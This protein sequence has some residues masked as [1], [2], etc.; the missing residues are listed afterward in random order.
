MIDN[1]TMIS[2]IGNFCVIRSP[3]DS[4]KSSL[5][6]IIQY[7]LDTCCVLINE[8]IEYGL[9]LYGGILQMFV[10]LTKNRTE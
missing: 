9:I 6:S 1:L 10:Y 5:R 8:L 2:Y 3:Q 4:V 7:H